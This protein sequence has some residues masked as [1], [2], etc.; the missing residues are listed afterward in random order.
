[1]EQELRFDQR[2]T[3]KL[4]VYLPE[5]CEG[6]TRDLSASGAYINLN[7]DKSLG[8]EVDLTIEVSLEKQRVRL[9][10][11][12]VVVR[13]ESNGDRNGVAIKFLDSTIKPL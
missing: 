9:V 1:M 6:L 13:V 3:L 12:G 11:H 8:T 10:C 4:P 2:D 7:C 5:G